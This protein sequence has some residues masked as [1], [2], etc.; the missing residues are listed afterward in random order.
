VRPL[1]YCA[2][3]QQGIDIATA[4]GTWSFWDWQGGRVSYPSLACL[5]DLTAVL[6][7]AVYPNVGDPIP[8]DLAGTGNYNLQFINADNGGPVWTGPG[9]YV[10]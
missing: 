6:V 7:L 4:G 8:L 2:H 3:R 1:C 9:K 5:V 10:H